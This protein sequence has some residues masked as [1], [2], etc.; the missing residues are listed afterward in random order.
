MAP[1]FFALSSQKNVVIC[2]WD[3]GNI[4]KG[5]FIREHWDLGL[6]YTLAEMLGRHPSTSVK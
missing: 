6:G 3:Q 2:N 5:S 1:R 4:K